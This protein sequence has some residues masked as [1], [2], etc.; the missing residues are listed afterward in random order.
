LEQK[1]KAQQQTTG[2]KLKAAVSE[3]EKAERAEQSESEKR[4]SGGHPQP[5][6]EAVLSQG[7]AHERDAAHG[8]PDV[9]DHR[10]GLRAADRSRFRLRA[11]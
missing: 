6:P 8:Q 7:P 1:A 2:E 10:S 9:A 11:K 4:T 5:R 3:H